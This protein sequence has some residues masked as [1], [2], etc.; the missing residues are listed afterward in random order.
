MG[1]VCF[2]VG[3]LICAWKSRGK[4]LGIKTLRLYT[5]LQ[6]LADHH[7]VR[8]FSEE[9]YVLMKKRNTMDERITDNQ[10]VIIVLT[11]F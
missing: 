9:R 4:L 6:T 8:L 2:C 5:I 10:L 3:Q 1:L 7:I 11:S